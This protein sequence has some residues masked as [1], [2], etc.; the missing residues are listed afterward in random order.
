MRTNFGSSLKIMQILNPKHVFILNS[1]SDI[2]NEKLFKQY[3]STFKNELYN[4][5]MS[6]KNQCIV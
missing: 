6:P 2:N 1:S 3:K 4:L 5:A